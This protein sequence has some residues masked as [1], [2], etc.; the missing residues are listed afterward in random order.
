MLA[1]VVVIALAGVLVYHQ[2]SATT[3]P[4]HPTS[5]PRHAAA[6]FGAAYLGVLGGSLPGSALPDTT[7]AIRAHAAGE[8]RIPA[9]SRFGSLRLTSVQTRWVTG[10]DVAQARIVGQDRRHTYPT[11][12]D[13]TYAGGAWR[14]VALVPPDVATILAR[15][16]RPPAV[17]QPLSAA[18]RAFALAYANYREGATIAAPPGL[19]PIQGQIH[20]GSDPL[21][22]TQPTHVPANLDSLAFGPVEGNI[23]AASATLND[24]GSALVFSFN[25]MRTGTQWRAWSFPETSG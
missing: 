16:H 17:A 19:P 12:L 14:V 1:L 15:P 6:A 4:P 3:T 2:T 24:R 8:A 13:L 22:Q 18:A 9:G 23:V 20:T 5:S 21:A 11:D 25:L 7:A 10:A